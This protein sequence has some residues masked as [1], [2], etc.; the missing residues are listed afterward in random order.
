MK[1]LNNKILIVCVFFLM[2][3]PA[4]AGEVVNVSIQELKDLIEKGVQVIDVRTKSEWEKT[5]VVKDSHLLTFYDE[6]GNYDLDAWLADVARVAN[7]D[8][9]V[10][11]ICHAGVRSR[12]LANYLVNKADYEK[13]YNVTRGIVGW[14]K[15][16]NPTEPYQ[17][18]TE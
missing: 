2:S 11:L 5:G 9:P 1:L 12:R 13:V 8:E 10:I 16:K 15:A 4:Y 17:A 3:A 14:I 7:K 6:K 18:P